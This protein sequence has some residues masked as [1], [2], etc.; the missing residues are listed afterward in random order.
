MIVERVGGENHEKRNEELIGRVRQTRTISFPTRNLITFLVFP[1]S[2]NLR[3]VLLDKS[4]SLRGY[5]IIAFARSFGRVLA[6]GKDELVKLVNF[7]ADG[8]SI[9]GEA[10]W[11]KR[12][13]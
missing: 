11:S 12:I 2:R 5:D 13:L 4:S 9:E 7:E 10:S 1:S 8:R 3:W 6:N